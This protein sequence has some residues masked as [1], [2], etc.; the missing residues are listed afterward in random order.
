MSICLLLLSAIISTCR[1]EF[2][3]ELALLQSLRHPNIVQFLG[4][5]TKTRPLVIVTEYFPKV[6]SCFQLTSFFSVVYFHSSTKSLWNSMWSVSWKYRIMLSCRKHWVCV[7]SP[8]A[9]VECKTQSGFLCCDSTPSCSF[10]LSLALFFYP[11][12]IFVAFYPKGARLYVTRARKDLW[13]Q[14]RKLAAP[15]SKFS[16]ACTSSQLCFDSQGDLANLLERRGRLD[17][18]TAVNFAL[19]IARYVFVYLQTI[20]LWISWGYMNLQWK[21]HVLQLEKVI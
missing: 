1:K 15:S 7:T 8:Y 21:E 4:A 6:I 18:T 14:C 5:V 11:F 9:W 19:D 2:I 16:S 12:G 13:P 17:A 3:G 20:L 10:P